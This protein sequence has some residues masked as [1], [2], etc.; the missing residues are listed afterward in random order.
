MSLVLLLIIVIIANSD[1]P[2]SSLPRAEGAHFDSHLGLQ[3]DESGPL[4]QTRVQ[5]LGDIARWAEN[6]DEPMYAVDVRPTRTR[7]DKQVND[8]THCL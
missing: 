3:Q 7:W 6:V 1:K 4:E 5:L 2:V 8:C